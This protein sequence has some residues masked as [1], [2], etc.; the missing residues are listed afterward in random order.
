MFANVWCTYGCESSWTGPTYF[1]IWKKTPSILGGADWNPTCIC[2][3]G[4]TCDKRSIIIKPITEW[5]CV[6]KYPVGLVSHKNC[7][8][9]LSNHKIYSEA[10]FAPCRFHR[11]GVVGCPKF[12]A[13]LFVPIWITLAPGTFSNLGGDASAGPSGHKVTLKGRRLPPSHPE[14]LPEVCVRSV[15]P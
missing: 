12:F 8:V 2:G 6:Q 10:N 5:A 3:N 9:I 1:F 13:S 4:R 14:L 15:H 7:V 11:K